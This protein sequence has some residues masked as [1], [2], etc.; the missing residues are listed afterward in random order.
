[1]SQIAGK[2][3]LNGESYNLVALSRC[4]DQKSYFPFVVGGKN[5][6]SFLEFVHEFWKKA[7]I[8]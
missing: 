3:C 5:W 6:N 7:Y 8:F 1:M 4:L 2:T